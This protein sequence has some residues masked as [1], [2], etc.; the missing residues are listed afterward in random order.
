MVLAAIVAPATTR[1][2]AAASLLLRITAGVPVSVEG[3][4]RVVVAAEMLMH[5]DRGA[6]PAALLRLVD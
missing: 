6:W 1:V 2:V 5:R 3:V 4:T